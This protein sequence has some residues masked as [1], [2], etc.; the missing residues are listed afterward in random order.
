MDNYP[1]EYSLASY[2][3]WH[4]ENLEKGK[5]IVEEVDSLLDELKSNN[6]DRLLKL[7]DL[8]SRIHSFHLLA[9]RVKGEDVSDCE[10]EIQLQDRLNQNYDSLFKTRDSVLDKLWRKNKKLRHE[11]RITS[12]TLKENFGDLVR[13]SIVTSTFTYAE[14]LASS[15]S[16]WRDLINELQIDASDYNDIESID[17]QQEAKMDNGYFAY[18]LDVRYKDGLRVEV[19]IYS[20][21]SEVWRHISHKLYE[22]IRLGEEVNWGHGAAASRIVSLGH[23]LHLAECEVQHLKSTISK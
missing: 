15:I 5:L 16:L 2:S 3:N 7:A 13:T 23:L 4:D 12:E 8:L 14:N 19:Q 18:H 20:K 22:K 9:S 17:T 6:R 11:E 1:K 10:T 21:L